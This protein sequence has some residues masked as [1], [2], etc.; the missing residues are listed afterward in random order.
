[1]ATVIAKGLSVTNPSYNNIGGAQFVRVVATGQTTVTVDGADSTVLGELYLHAA[2]DEIIVEKSPTDR[3]TCAAG[4][5]AAVG[6]PR[7]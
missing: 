6:S 5:A 3:I 7:S 4:I 1:M 2:G